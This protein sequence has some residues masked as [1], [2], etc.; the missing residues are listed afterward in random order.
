MEDGTHQTVTCKAE[1][2]EI[3]EMGNCAYQNTRTW[4]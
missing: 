4:D 2:E 3:P 1:C